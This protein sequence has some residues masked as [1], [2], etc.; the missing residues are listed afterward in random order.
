MA[1]PPVLVQVLRER[2]RSLAGWAVAFAA[3]CGMYTSIYPYMAEMNLQAMLEALPREMIE[4]LGYDDM[5]SAAGY[6]GSATYGLV[7]FAL[8][9]VFAIGNGAALLA[10]DEESGALELELTS[11]LPRAAIY[12]QRLGALWAQITALVAVVFAVTLTL[13]LAQGLGIPTLDLAAATLQLWL[14]IGLFGSL[15]FAA[16]AATGRRGIGLGVAATLAV[17]SWMLNAIGPTIGLEWMSSI[18][19]V[20]WYMDSNPITRGFHPVDAL[21]LALAAAL[22]I[23]AGLRRFVRRDLMT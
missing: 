14:L 16:G 6:V 18:S 1:A 4:A 21:L 7:A 15:A 11:P 3:I 22:V 9:M 23:A 12:V 20:G 8:L 19:P 17:V 10:G 13:D 5:S 2:R